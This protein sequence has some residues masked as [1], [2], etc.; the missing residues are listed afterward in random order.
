MLLIEKHLVGRS[1]THELGIR[2]LERAVEF[3]DQPAAWPPEVDD[4]ALA[5]R[6]VENDL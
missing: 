6:T 1:T 4:I 3:P 5:A 2:V